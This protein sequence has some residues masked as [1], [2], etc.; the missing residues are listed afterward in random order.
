MRLLIF[1]LTFIWALIRINPAKTIMIGVALWMFSY[2]GTIP[3]TKHEIKF[4]HQFELRGKWVGIY[5]DDFEAMAFDKAPNLSGPDKDT[6]RWKEYHPANV[7]LWV[8]FWILAFIVVIASFTDDG[9]WEMGDVFRSGISVFARC[10]LE[11]DVYIY[12]IFGR[13]VCKSRRK[14]DMEDI[15]ELKSPVSILALPRYET[16]SSKRDRILRMVGI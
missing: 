8:G 7:F 12:T 3:D 13:L 16:K 14:Q 15:Y 6:Y 9:E 2:A 4:F 11:N 5:G 10:E 1:P